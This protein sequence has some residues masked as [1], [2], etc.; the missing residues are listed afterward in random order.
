M[1][2]RRGRPSLRLGDVALYVVR[3][4]KAGNRGE[5]EGPDSL[6]PLSRK[7]HKQ[8]ERLA[9]QL[10]DR[11]IKRVASSPYVRC[12]ETVQPLAARLGVT[13]E[14]DDALA[15][16]ART[17]DIV[18]L[19][20]ELM[21]ENAVVCTHGDMGP[22]LIEALRRSDGLAVPRHFQFAKGSTWVLEPDGHGHF[23]KGVYLPAP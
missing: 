19:A 14:T 21:P 16:G 3:H 7:G 4:A 22:A 17:E 23:R 6:R 1:L 15:E 11:G 5:W 2:R 9:D 20:R 13:V 18:R 10:A 8:A 12:V